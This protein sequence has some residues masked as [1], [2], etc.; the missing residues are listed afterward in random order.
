MENRDCIFLLDKDRGEYWSE[1]F[2]K[3]CFLSIL[4]WPNRP[5]TILKKPLWTSFLRPEA[6]PAA[7]RLVRMGKRRSGTQLVRYSEAGA[8]RRGARLCQKDDFLVVE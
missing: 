7:A 1:P 3:E 4:T 8:P 6:R 2:F 5:P